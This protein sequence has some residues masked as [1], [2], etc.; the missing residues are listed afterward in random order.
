MEERILLIKNCRQEKANE[1]LDILKKKLFPKLDIDLVTNHP[2]LFLNDKRINSI[3]SGRSILEGFLTLS[4]LQKKRFECV[5]IP[6]VGDGYFRY[7]FLPFIG[8]GK[9]LLVFSEDLSYSYW[10]KGYFFC[11]PFKKSIKNLLFLTFRLIF[12]L[13]SFIYLFICVGILFG[14]RVYYVWYE[15]KY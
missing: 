9:H 2:Q 6:L 7:K 14:K 12:L 10:N 15:H 1:I 13:A 4:N 11:Y 8:F 3:Y 5:V